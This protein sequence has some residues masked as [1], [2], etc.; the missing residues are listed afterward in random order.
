VHM[1]DTRSS[2]MDTALTF[3]IYVWPKVD[4]SPFESVLPVSHCTL[5]VI[6]QSTLAKHG[7]GQLCIIKDCSV[8]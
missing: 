5:L 1:H 3:I 8:S 7:I 6:S 4:Y 2:I